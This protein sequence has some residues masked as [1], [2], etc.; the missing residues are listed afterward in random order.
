MNMND[1]KVA[2][3]YIANDTQTHLSVPLPEVEVTFAGFSGD[4]HAGLTMLAGSHTSRYPRGTEIRNSRQVSVISM[5]ELAQVSEE[6]G[7]ACIQ[8]EWLEANLAL[9]GIPELT[10]LP[11]GTRL[12]FEQEATLVVS[13]EN[14][15]CVGPGRIVQTHYPEME[16][17]ANLFPKASLHKRGLVCFVER[18]GRI[19]VGDGVQ[20][21][22]PG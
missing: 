6:M 17:L 10:T 9:T 22:L 19:A 8:P 12:F 14:R 16:G 1:V 15:P 21:E 7:I 11:I 4:K 2:G 3:V 18:P 5:E 20:I 13:L